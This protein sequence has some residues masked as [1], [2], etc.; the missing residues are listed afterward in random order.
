MPVTTDA[1][2]L[3]RESLFVGPFV[4]A[5]H[6]EAR[7]QGLLVDP[8]AFD[9]TRSGALARGDFRT[10][11]SG[12]SGRGGGKKP[13]L[14]AQD[15]FRVCADIHEQRDPRRGCK[16]FLKAWRRPHRLRHDRQCTAAYRPERPD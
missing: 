7:F 11:E 1:A 10:F 6:L 4:N 14:V 3:F 12:A 5:D 16:G 8:D 15:D 2:D 9:R 13:V